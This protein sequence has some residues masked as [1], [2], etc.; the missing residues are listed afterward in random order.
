MTEFEISIQERNFRISGFQQ[1][2]L[3]TSSGKILG[4]KTLAEL[5]GILEFKTN[6]FRI[7]PK[8]LHLRPSAY[9]VIKPGQEKYITL[10]GKVPPYLRNVEVIIQPNR[11]LS[12]FC[13]SQMLVKFKRG[14]T[15]IPVKNLSHKTIHVAPDK[16]LASLHLSQLVDVVQ[17]LPSQYVTELSGNDALHKVSVVSS[18]SQ[19]VESTIVKDRVKKFG[20]K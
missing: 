1:W 11:F 14:R 5:D 7:A 6:T 13:P 9:V 4:S 20:S 8:K 18:E 12:K 10:R 15:S 17:T 16:P 3:K 19:P 2:L